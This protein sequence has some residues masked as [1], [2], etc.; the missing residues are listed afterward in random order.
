VVPERDRVGAGGEDP[1]RQLRRQSDAVGGVLA[2][3]DAHVDVE[4]LAEQRQTLLQYAPARMS[5]DVGDEE[6]DQGTLRAAAE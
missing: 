5:D 4:L 2:V 3:D 6:K 1:L